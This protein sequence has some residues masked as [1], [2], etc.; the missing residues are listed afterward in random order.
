MNM[1]YR[2]LLIGFVLFGATV[3]CAQ[4]PTLTTEDVVK[5]RAAHPERAE[6][7]IPKQSSASP[8]SSA[9]VGTAFQVAEQDWNARLAAA[10]ERVR[11]CERRADETDLAATQS[12][13]RIFHG[14]A[15]AL[16]A[17]NARVAQLQAFAHAYRAEARAAQ[18]VVNLLLDEGREVGYQLAALSPTLKDGAP[19]VAY[20]RSRFLD[21][22]RDLQDAQGR[23]EVL[24]QRVNRLQTAINTTWNAPAYSGRRGIPFYP[25]N[26]AADVFYLNRLRDELGGVSGDAQAAQARIVI[27]TEQLQALQEEGRRAGVP[28]G[29]FR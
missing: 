24:Q 19:N 22:Q 28:P 6:H 13:N 12:R 10:R 11:A 3:V 20:Y 4:R 25:N 29:V 21:L 9:P 17:N 7:F 23:A 18:A 26:G 2:S 16:N 14:N 5:W 27:L 1:Q 15:N 8:Q